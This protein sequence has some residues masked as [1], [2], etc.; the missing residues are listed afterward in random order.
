VREFFLDVSEK[1]VGHWSCWRL[2]SAS[3]R[4]MSILLTALDALPEREIIL[5][6]AVLNEDVQAFPPSFDAL[7]QKHK[8][9]SLLPLQRCPIYTPTNASNGFVTAEYLESLLPGR[10]ADY[11]FCGPQPFMVRST[12]I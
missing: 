9:E 5:V 10:D 3:R 11:Y 4:S 7:A 6:H 1:H 2:V 8:T 12:M